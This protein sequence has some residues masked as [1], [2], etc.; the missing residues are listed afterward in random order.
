MGVTA[1]IP[2]Y[3]E[4]KTV[5]KVVDVLKQVVSITEIIV[6]DDGSEDA[7]AATARRHGAK[8][9]KLGINSGKGAAMTAGA[10]QAQEEILLFL[11]ADLEGLT[12][13]HVEALITP[14]V[15][16]ITDMTV[17]VFCHGRSF[18]DLAQTVAP[19]L[20]GQRSIRKELFLAVG[21]E[22][23]RFEVEILLNS[24]ARRHGWR[25]QRVP[26][27]NMTHVMKEEK[28]G[29]YR[30]VLARIGMYKDIVKF[31]WRWTW[32]KA[33]SGSVA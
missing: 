32:K 6:V 2:A 13:F 17:G 23:S 3:N 24:E 19:Q 27:T 7:T 29:L 8:V 28:R 31:F 9:I 11:D 21:A 12:P 10:R 26:L 18:T 33:K 22:S 16:G 1:I 25:V 30:G 14:L 15:D 20:S 4:A 5:G